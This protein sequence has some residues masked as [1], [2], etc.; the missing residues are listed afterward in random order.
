M[1]RL[2]NEAR[3]AMAVLLKQGH[4]QSAVARLLG[5][6]EGTV[7]YHRRRDAAG[8]VDGRSKQASKAAAVA[9]AIAHWRSQ[10]SDGR[11]NLAALHEW[12]QREHGYEGSLKSVQ[13]YWKRT[14]PAPAIRARRRVETPIGAQAQVDWAEYPGMV[15]GREVVDLVALVVTLSWSRKRAVS[16]A[17]SK[18]ML[19]WQA[20]QTACLRRLGGAPAV[21]RID[22]VKTAIAKG[23]GAWGV[24]N[25]TYRRYAV[26][27][28]FHVD[29]CQPRHPQGKGKVE[30]SVRDQREAFDVSGLVF[31]SLEALQTW[32]DARL[33]ERATHLRCPATGAS[34][35]EA[36]EQERRLLTPLPE[37]LPEPF[38]IVVRRPV[39]VD[40]MISFEGRRYSVPFRFVNQEVEVRGLSGRVQVLKDCQVIAEHPRATAALLLYNET[41]FEGDGTASVRAPMPLGRMGRRLQEITAANVQ[42]RSIEIYAQLA[43]VAR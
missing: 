25:E 19:S 35:A 2:E 30:R 27:M 16:W 3:T 40:C 15:I 8:A 39:G 12:L 38:D 1:G 20:C 14:F 34:V 6:N 11:V 41:H 23:A 26:Q 29:A 17:R 21:L 31:E 32:T 10:H 9:E 7:R 28:R 4:S 37:T 42:H 5:V 22:N 43:E 24:I 13:R 33:E 18:D 36:W